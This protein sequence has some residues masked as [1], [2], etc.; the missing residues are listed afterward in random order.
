MS[1]KI[2]RTTLLF[3][4]IVLFSFTI[5]ISIALTNVETLLEKI[6][7]DDSFYEFSISRNIARGKPGTY[8][9]VD[10]TNSIHPLWILLISIPYLITQNIYLAINIILVFAS[11]VDIFT[12]IIIFKFAEKIFDQKTAFLSSTLYGLNPFVTFQTLNG[13]ETVLSVFFV[14]LTFYSYFTFRNKL[15]VRRIL[16]LG[17]ILGLAMLARAD[18]ILLVA[19][20]LL[21]ILYDERKNFKSTIKTCFVTG[22]IALIIFS[23]FLLWSFFTFGRIT[24]SS[25]IARYNMNHGI[26]PFFDLKPP[27]SLDD[28][29]K[30]IGENTYRGLGIILHQLGVINF[31]FFSPSVILPIFIVLVLLFSL[32]ELKKIK[33]MVLY[34]IFLFSFYC[35]YF[36]G[37]QIRYFTSLMPLFFILFSVG[38]QNL[39]KSRKLLSVVFM[40]F[41]FVLFLN[42]LKQWENGYLSWQREIYKD[43]LWIRE[44]AKD[45]D[46]IASFNSGILTYF[47][48]K[49]VVNMDGVLNA[50]A[51]EALSNRSVI[52]YMKSKNIT[53]WVDN[54]FFNQT[55]ADAYRKG[56]RFNVLE[57][58]I[59]QDVLGEGKESLSLIEQ[60]EGIYR[61]LRGFEM[62][63]VF[64]KAK[65]IY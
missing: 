49:R 64:F 63:V 14:M 8:N 22:S 28:H 52:K 61:H 26:F 50:E 43:S 37:V 25:Y 41:I 24:L 6:L 11:I 16:I 29:F 23:P 10:T 57:N 45:T 18:N 36:L 55:V 20:L 4:L 47:S 44:N 42:G 65:L 27:T 32:K 1:L 17:L 51:I 59:W 34:S 56:L 15:T 12:M 60:R 33:P 3:L 46:V 2:K 31:D 40:L 21:S 62:L 35:F 58:N 48:E 9:G 7:I 53:I 19:S 39:F 38:F 30:L 5:R 54:V 13:M